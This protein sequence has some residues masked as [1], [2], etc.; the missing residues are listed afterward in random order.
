MSAPARRAADFT[1]ICPL[2]LSN[3][4]PSNGSAGQ[5]PRGIRRRRGRTNGGGDNGRKIDRADLDV[6]V[7]GHRLREPDLQAAADLGAGNFA[8]DIGETERSFGQCEPQRERG[9]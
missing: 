3:R 1:L 4:P 2:R 5:S 7:D 6:A 9:G 8:G